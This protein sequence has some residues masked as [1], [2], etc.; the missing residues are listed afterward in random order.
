MREK[1]AKDL[2]E[3][4][5]KLERL[6]ASKAA[7]TAAPA[8]A[9]APAPGAAPAAG[10]ENFDDYL[11]SLLTSAVPG[12]PAPAPAPPSAVAPAATTA[13]TT[14]A[15][16]AAT[17][18]A[19][20][21]AAAGTVPAPSL[22]ERLSR[23][24]MSES[25][26]VVSIPSTAAERA[27]MYD[28]GCQAGTGEIDAD[29]E[30]GD[31]EAAVVNKADA[32]AESAGSKEAAAAATTAATTAAAAAA[33]AAAATEG[34][35][36][37]GGGA[38]ARLS[39]EERRKLMGTEAF[40]AFLGRSSTLVERA[41][42][43]SAQWDFMV[44]YAD[45]GEA[46]GAGAGGAG[47]AD[48]LKRTLTFGG[49]GDADGDGK[50][51]ASSSSSSP[52]AGGAA[53]GGA[54]ASQYC[55]GRAVT[56]MSWSPF[57]DELLLVSY[58][59]RGAGSG[60]AHD[61]MGG[62][63]GQQHHAAAGGGGGGGGGGSSLY[64]ADGLVLVWGTHLASRPEMAFSCQSPV[65]AAT[66][67]PF[68]RHLIVGATYEGQIV[69]WD[70]RAKAA[71]VQRTVL[72]EHGHTHPIFSLSVV[73]SQNAHSLVTAS[74]DGKLCEWSLANLVRPSSAMQ[75]AH[76]PAP[77]K[78]AGGG[79][80][81]GGGGDVGGGGSADGSSGAPSSAAASSS[82]G[83]GSGSGGGVTERSIDVAA[84]AM[85][86]PSHDNAKFVVGGEDGG[87]YEAL[88]HGGRGGSAGV[89]GGSAGV[90]TAGGGAGRG[91]AGSGLGVHTRH[92]GHAAPITAMHY[93]PA[94][95]AGGAA[96]GQ[97]A[98]SDLLLSAS[99]DW[100]AKLWNFKLSP[101]PLLS[102]EHAADY[103]FDV[104]WSPKHPALFA[105]ADGEGF[106]DLWHLNRD[107]EA[108]VARTRV[109]ERAL[110]KVRFSNDG[111]RIAVGDSGGTA[112]L[113]DVNKEVRGSLPLPL[114]CGPP[115]ASSPIAAFVLCTDPPA[116]LPPLALVPLQLALPRDDE[117]DI[118]CRVVE[119][120]A[121]QLH[122]SSF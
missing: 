75:L 10:G 69:L 72:S 85:S 73:G 14:A 113:Y 119:A 87:V 91:G 22:A 4:K 47:A 79:G 86:F 26:A 15:T 64:S 81:G 97:G 57:F 82:S 37:G 104:Q 9:A 63:G 27:E 13:A 51:S 30:G 28:K 24:S 21:A 54:A 92:D 7:R 99:M 48:L 83:S 106:L 77:L 102:F 122:S 42:A 95:G 67:D 107:F 66:F 17:A 34:E 50:A 74:T 98:T 2:E 29:G 19:P 31:G 96:A 43:Q 80:G 36:S 105:T 41:L 93:H 46:G 5:K 78:K 103:V 39:A 115:H 49:G 70:T 1:R 52:L 23:L 44:D 111:R 68:D 32:A 60:A 59:E 89:G 58:S 56:D 100:T 101:R 55:A 38:T 90:G 117:T 33:A 53:A 118:L 76:T 110:S 35:G 121:E 20:A 8:A 18:A 6:R 16:A 65:L 61:G 62:L 120:R 40:T 109:G 94:L 88:L 11:N 71:P 45:D 112:R 25:I 12:S 84:T 114:P 108:P 3:K 116:P